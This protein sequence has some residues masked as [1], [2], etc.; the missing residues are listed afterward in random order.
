MNVEY[1]WNILGEVHRYAL[2]VIR[3]IVRNVSQLFK[4]V[5]YALKMEKIGF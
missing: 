2:D 4:N 1:V 3:Y 5:Q